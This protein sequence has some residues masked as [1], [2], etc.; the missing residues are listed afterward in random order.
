MAERK[1]EYRRVQRGKRVGIL[2]EAPSLQRVFLD[3]GLAFFQSLVTGSRA[4]I[5]L[6][7]VP[8][9]LALQATNS[10][11]LFKEWAVALLNLYSVERFIVS[12][13]IFE[14]FDGKTLN[15]VLHG[16]AYTPLA[17]GAFQNLGT[18]DAAKCLLK[19]DGPTE[20]PFSAEF[21]WLP[22]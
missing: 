21:L 13:A 19:T 20:I 1:I 9:R 6:D 8:K 2:V 3:T 12:R 10:Q 17:H 7:P 4:E 5:P 14:K 16:S 18:V 15:A 11:G 22:T